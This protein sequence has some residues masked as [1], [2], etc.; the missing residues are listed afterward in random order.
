MALCGAF[1]FMH[2]VAPCSLR[3]SLILPT[4]FLLTLGISL[5]SQRGVRHLL[6]G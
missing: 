1:S 4:L 2:I 5:F 3:I 6:R